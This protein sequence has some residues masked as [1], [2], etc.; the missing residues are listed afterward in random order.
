MSAA[1]FDRPSATR[2]ALH[3]SGAVYICRGA[4]Q[5]AALS[6][7]EPCGSGWSFREKQF[8]DARASFKLSARG[9]SMGRCDSM[10]SVVDVGENGQRVIIHSPQSVY[11]CGK[12][13]QDRCDRQLRLT[14]EGL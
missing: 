1:L 2:Q 4:A 11:L 3:Y 13:L 6:V 5:M 8:L 14:Q 12:R 7:Q 9:R 10:S